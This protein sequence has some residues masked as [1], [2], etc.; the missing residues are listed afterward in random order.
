VESKLKS[1]CG[2]MQVMGNLKTTGIDQRLW[3]DYDRLRQATGYPIV[4]I[5]AQR[6]QDGVFLADLDNHRIPAVGAAR[7]QMAY[8]ALD[9]LPR[10]CSYSEL[11]A[12]PAASQQMELPL[13]YPPA[14]WDQPPLW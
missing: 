3:N 12:T 1:T 10:L 13:F 2:V 14:I 5:F 9:Y 4:L 8:W 7:G 6:E 11:M